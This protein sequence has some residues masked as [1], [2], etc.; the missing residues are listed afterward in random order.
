[1]VEGLIYKGVAVQKA[2]TLANGLIRYALSQAQGSLTSQDAKSAVSSVN[3][4][5]KAVIAALI[6][7]EKSVNCFVAPN[8][9]Y[10]KRPL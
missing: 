9:N 7:A 2:Y 6:A 5:E 3:S 1:M 4:L 10:K 8:P